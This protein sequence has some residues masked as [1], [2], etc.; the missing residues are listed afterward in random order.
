MFFPSAFYFLAYAAIACLFPFLPLYYQEL[1]LTGSQI[2]ILAGISPLIS[3]VGM[4]FW[5]GIADA[6]RRHKEMLSFAIIGAVVMVFIVSQMTVFLWLIPLIALYAFFTAPIFSLADSATMHALGERRERY[7]R[8]RIWGTAGW[9]LTAPLIGEIIERSGIQWAFWGYIILMLAGLFIALSLAFDA[10]HTG[11]SFSSGMRILLSNRRWIFFLLMV[12]V[13]GVGL[14]A[15]NN[16]LFIYMEALG[17]SKTLMG[18][19]LTVSTLSELPVMFFGDRL[20]K[21]FGPRGLLGL[22]MGVIGVRLLLYSATSLPW[23]IMAIQL[24]HGLTFPAVYIA[25]VSYADHNAPLGLKA[26]AQGMFGS[27]LMGFGAAAGGL[28]GGILLEQGGPH[29]MYRI[30]GLIVLAGLLLL[31]ILERSQRNRHET[32]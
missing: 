1:G 13:S 7:G 32:I 26:T 18:L 12:F 2:G 17:A 9:G 28:L 14:A 16:Y 5:T 25:G 24:I 11:N 22:A 19:A 23:V 8:V 31:F 29:S 15:I 20:L 10:S 30:V 27:A 6:T 21:R 4:P 3:M